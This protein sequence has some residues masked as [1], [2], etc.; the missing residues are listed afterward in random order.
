MS[1]IEVNAVSRPSGFPLQKLTAVLILF[2]SIFLSGR[3]VVSALESS[4]PGAEYDWGVLLLRDGKHE[5]ARKKFESEFRGSFKIATE[6]WLD[7]ICISAMLGETHYQMGNHAEALECFN[8]ALRLSIQYSDWLTLVQNVPNPGMFTLQPVPWGDPNPGRGL[9]HIPEKFSI[10]FGDLNYG[11][12][13][14]TGGVAVPPSLKSIRGPEIVRCTMLAIRRRAE[15]L[16]PLGAGDDLTSEL[17]TRLGQTQRSLAGT[18]F[19]AWLEMEIGFCHLA[20]GKTDDAAQSLMRGASINGNAHLF[21]PL[22][23]IELGRLQM[24]AGNYD[25]AYALFLDAATIAYYY[26]D[27]E[28][29]TE[30][31]EE[32]ACAYFQKDPQVICPSLARAAEWARSE[33]L[34]YLYATLQALR[35]DDFMRF[36][37]ARPAM[38]CLALAEKTIGK[39]SISMGRLGAALHYLRARIAFLDPSPNSQQLGMTS[40]MQAMRFMQKGA[41]WNFHIQQVDFRLLNGQITARKALEAYELLLREPTAGDW[42]MDPMESLAVTMTPRPGTWENYFLCAV[43]MERKDTALEISEKARRAAYLQTLDLGGRIH[44]LR[45]LLES[46]E[47]DL[48]VQ[49]LQRKRD[50]LTEYPIYEQSS[51]EVRELQMKV[52]QMSLPVTEREEGVELTQTLGKIAELTRQQEAVLSAM[53]LDR[54]VIDVVFPKVRTCEEIQA[55]LPKG[56]AMLVYYAARNQLFLFLLNRERLA[57]WKIV[58][59]GAGAGSARKNKAAGNVLTSLQTN[60]VSMLKEMGLGAGNIRPESFEETKWK[61]ASQRVMADLT[62][63]SQ[64]DFSRADFDSLVIVPDRFAWYIP[65][66]ALQIQTANGPRPTI[67]QFAVRYAP[68]ASLGTPWKRTQLPKSPYTLIAAGKNAPGSKVQDRLEKTL[69]RPVLFE[70]KSYGGIQPGTPGTASSIYAAMFDK[71][72]VFQDL[73]NDEGAAFQIFP[74][75]LDYGVKEGSLGYWFLLPYGAPR[76]VVLPGMRTQCESLLKKSAKRTGTASRQTAVPGQEFFL[77]SMAFLANGSDTVVLPRWNLEGTSPWRL[78][79]HFLT[80]LPEN[81]NSAQ[82]WRKA[83]LKFASSEIRPEAEPRIAKGDELKSISCSHPFFWAGYVL[84]DSGSGSL[85]TREAF[86]R[87]ETAEGVRGKAVGDP[88][89]NAD[90]IPA[91]P[92]AEEEANAPA[93]RPLPLEDSEKN[94][95]DAETDPEEAPAVNGPLA[96]LP[97]MGGTLPESDKKSVPIPPMGGALP[98]E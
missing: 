5:E 82:A 31:F 61:T 83:V 16:G 68:M 8:T 17:M 78:T 29:M 85:K 89:G 23:Y 95:P 87:E 60:F 10:L 67:A 88:V 93:R 40:L 2:F 6:R 35:A 71:M 11:T 79:T 38:E 34:A 28:S 7:S 58:D 66:E 64:A 13:Y 4:L 52:R 96:P 39:R 12:T 21:T 53:V 41:V 43:E 70:E 76:L 15:L 75:G 20:L 32:L 97:P 54:R 26:E 94:A 18:W 45:L 42:S 1:K 47:S 55:S 92:R 37:Q 50:I 3:S 49:Q 91:R 73:R 59:S 30:A 69:E 14:R 24:K 72:L 25:K 9:L 33:K 74:M 90:G 19:Q 63:N 46:P 77:T 80:Q 81:E 36:H 62:K 27:V 65:F 51:K 56:E 98:L 22:A 84:I 48:T 57:M 44:S 86:R